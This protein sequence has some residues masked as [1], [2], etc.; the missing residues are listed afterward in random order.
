MLT[1]DRSLGKRYI[2][3]FLYGSTGPLSAGSI[4]CRFR[5]LL[6]CT[7]V[8]LART[9]VLTSV[10]VVCYPIKTCRSSLTNAFN[11]GPLAKC[12]KVDSV[13]F[14]QC[15]LS[16]SETTLPQSEIAVRHHLS[17]QPEQSN[18]RQL[19]SHW[20]VSG[21]SLASDPSDPVHSRSRS[22]NPRTSFMQ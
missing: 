21:S 12:N 1:R 15:L 4:V 6:F 5:R 14:F 20:S 8:L 9:W 16:F 22:C 3:I 10:H 11:V 17:W 7:L 19:W 18:H 13:C 2:S